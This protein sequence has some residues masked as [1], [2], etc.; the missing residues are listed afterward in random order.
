[1]NCKSILVS[2]DELHSPTGM[3]I[4]SKKH[5]T[6]SLGIVE[7]KERLLASGGHRTRTLHTLL[8]HYPKDFI[9]GKLRRRKVYSGFPLP[10][11]TVNDDS[12]DEGEGIVHR[13]KRLQQRKIYCLRHPHSSTLHQQGTIASVIIACQTPLANS[14]CLQPRQIYV[15]HPSHSPLSITVW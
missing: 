1:M 5:T 7:P 15:T 9:T 6:T 10:L 4:V 14:H 2:T 13:V 3:S 12:W 11:H 8:F